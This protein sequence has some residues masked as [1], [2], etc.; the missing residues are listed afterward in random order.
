MVKKRGLGKSL[1]A[2]LSYTTPSMQDIREEG[3][4]N[5]EAIEQEK[6]TQL[7]VD[8]IQRGKYQPRRE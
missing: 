7:S 6:L 1:D 8:L 5:K 2:L 4:D 3:S